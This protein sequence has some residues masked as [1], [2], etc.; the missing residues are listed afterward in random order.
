MSQS[1]GVFVL[2][3]RNARS[4]LI[5][6]N[7]FD[8]IGRVCADRK[9]SHR[10]SRAVAQSDLLRGLALAAGNHILDSQ[11][12]VRGQSGKLSCVLFPIWNQE[13]ATRKPA[14]V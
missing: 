9:G 11:D 12:Q 6:R 3:Q 14:T 2:C 5:V 13:P 8:Q 10:F 4:C 7:L 1:T